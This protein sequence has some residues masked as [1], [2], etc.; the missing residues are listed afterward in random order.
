MYDA[1][2]RKQIEDDL[3]SKSGLVVR[4]ARKLSARLP[5]SVSLDDLIQ[6]G[7][8]GL[9]ESLSSW[10]A[11][12]GVPF[13]AFASTRIRGAMLDELR[14]C[15]WL[16]KGVRSS[17]KKM[18]ESETA[19]SQKLGRL[20]SDSELASF[21]GVSQAELASL[22][23][24]E[25]SGCVLNIEGMADTSGDGGSLTERLASSEKTPDAVFFEKEFLKSLSSSIS[26]LP[27]KERL[28][29]SLYYDEG[30]NLKEIGL[31]LGVSESR[32]CQ[33]LGKTTKLL[34]EMMKEW[35]NES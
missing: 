14:R 22:V 17:V 28:V 11:G 24:D 30:L 27:E 6:V 34:G 3:S 32:A 18:E 26:S 10:D 9:L 29:L 25:F 21:M 19:L 8:L 4:I 16:P 23:K 7:M 12:K 35:K 15:D 20:P 1:K 5:S 31:V 13:D 2:G 33:M